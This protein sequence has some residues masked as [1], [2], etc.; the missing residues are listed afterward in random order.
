MVLM[1]WWFA[2]AAAALMAGCS[3]ALDWREVRPEG[4]GVVALLPCK[5]D[6]AERVVPLG[7]SPRTLRV[8]GCDAGGATFA[9]MRTELPDPGA[10]GATLA[11]WRTATL[12]HVRATGVAPLAFTPRGSLPLAESVRVQ[13][14]GQAPD[15]QPIQ[16][17]AVWLARTQGTGVE[18]VHAVVYGLPGERGLADA[19]EAFFSGI[20]LP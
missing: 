7:G 5:P 8:V 14:R 2:C 3:P 16:M 19:A 11:G 6:R 17:Q 20:R 18:L 13:A 1:K 15:G 4:S 9:L 10:A 12:A